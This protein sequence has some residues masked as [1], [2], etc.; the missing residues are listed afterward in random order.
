MN[1]ALENGMSFS[2]FMA[3]PRD[4][5]ATLYETGAYKSLH[6]KYGTNLIHGPM[7][8]QV[9]T[10]KASFWVRTLEDDTVEIQCFEF[11]NSKTMIKA[12]NITSSK[13]VDFT[14]IIEVKGL[15]PDTKYNYKVLVNGNEV[16]H[17]KNLNFKTYPL[18]QSEFS[19]GLGGGAGYTPQ[20][21]KMW[22]TI[23]SYNLDAM[24][25]MGDN[26]YIDIPEKPGAF[27]DYTYYRRQSQPDFQNMISSTPIYAIWDDHDAATDDAWLGPYVDKPSWKMPLFNVFKNKS[28]S[29]WLISVAPLNKGN[30]LLEEDSIA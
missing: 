9:T 5:L 1:R 2:R 26:V 27:H 28:Y 15:K 19:I 11:E 12:S 3:G 21:E 16:K 8:G 18:S 4:L 23:D 20:Y 13:G 7:I 14:N 22:N 10:T 17:L 24:L 25:L 6:K 29:L 30:C